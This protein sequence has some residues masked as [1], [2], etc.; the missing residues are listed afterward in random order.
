MRT[1]WVL[2]VLLFLTLAVVPV[3]AGVVLYDNGPSLLDSDHGAAISS[4]YE[5]SNS[6]SLSHP[7]IVT[8]VT[9]GA[10]TNNATLISVDWLITT[11]DFG[12]TVEASGTAFPTGSF[13]QFRFG[14]DF[15]TESFD[16]PD[17]ALSAGTY[18]LQLQNGATTSGSVWWKVS[19]GPSQAFVYNPG[20]SYLSSL[21]ESD[22]FQILG[23]VPEPGG[24]ALVGVGA[25]LLAFLRRRRRVR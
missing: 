18:W 14:Q 2:S 3:P 6:F 17:V 5:I 24:I 8:G 19:D 12:G 4:G 22:S 25:L 23:S 15:Y 16:I 10:N 13:V 21:D 1:S 9:F 11:S 7:S 20:Q